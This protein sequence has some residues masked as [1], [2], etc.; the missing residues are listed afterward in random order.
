MNRNMIPL[1]INTHTTN[2]HNLRC[3]E[4]RRNGEK[5]EIYQPNYIRDAS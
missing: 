1:Q 4:H 3:E 2:V 5:N